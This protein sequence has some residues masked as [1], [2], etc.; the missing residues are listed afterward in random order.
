MALQISTSTDPYFRNPGV[1]G[2]G[3][4]GTFG[5]SAF[6]SKQFGPCQKLIEN[7]WHKQLL[8]DMPIFGIDIHKSKYKQAYVWSSS[9]WDSL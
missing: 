6:W 3:L 9:S 1:G 7:P 8:E 5:P 2:G 4:F